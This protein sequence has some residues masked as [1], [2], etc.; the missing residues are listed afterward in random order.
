MTITGPDLSTLLHEAN[1]APWESLASALGMADG[2]PPP[3]VGRLVQHI[4]VTK[5]GYWEAVAAA[6]GTP[7]PSPELNLDGLCV[8]E[9]E[10]AAL[11]EPE[12]LAAPLTY[13]GAQ[14]SVA[15]LLCLNARHTVW[16]AGQ[17]AALCNGP[18]LA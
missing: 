2:Q 14:M 13:S 5:R 15:E 3:R 11:L 8:W 10:R 9:V 16:H 1:H 17:I 7:L 18:R 4:S 6:A 12:Q